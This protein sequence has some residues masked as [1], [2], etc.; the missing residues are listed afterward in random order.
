MALAPPKTK[1]EHTSFY[2][3]G[4]RRYYLR[5]CVSNVYFASQT[6]LITCPLWS[7][8][9]NHAGML[10]GPV[11]RTHWVLFH[12]CLDF[13]Q[14]FMGFFDSLYLITYSSSSIFITYLK[15]LP[16]FSLTT[17]KSL[18]L[19]VWL[20]GLSSRRLWHTTSTFSRPF[21]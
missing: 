14:C 21:A 5:C 13:I 12:L 17:R 7:V 20:R 8:S 11:E 18:L 2:L 1:V 4:K 16:V 19:C 3:M 15:C 6:A 10:G 9:L